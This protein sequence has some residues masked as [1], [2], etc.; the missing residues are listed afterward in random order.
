MLF[1]NKFFALIYENLSENQFNAKPLLDDVPENLKVYLKQI[2]EYKN[3]KKT[4]SIKK[5]KS[6]DDKKEEKKV[7]EKLDAKDLIK[8]IIGTSRDIQHSIELAI[9]SA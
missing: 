1:E 6:V 9:A 3:P 7:D 4:K 8:E 5:E 2:N